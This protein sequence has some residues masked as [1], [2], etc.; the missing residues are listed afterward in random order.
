MQVY[1]HTCMCVGVY[2]C[3]HACVRAYVYACTYV[4]LYNQ[5]VVLVSVSVNCQLPQVLAHLH[6]CNC[7]LVSL[8]NNMF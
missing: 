3:M 5:I 1:V 2:V 7:Y 8:K 6:N 4:W